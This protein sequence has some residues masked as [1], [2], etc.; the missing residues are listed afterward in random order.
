MG[1]TVKSMFLRILFFVPASWRCFSSSAEGGVCAFPKMLN[2]SVFTS[3]NST[4]LVKSSQ[5]LFCPA[6]RRVLAPSLTQLHV[7][8]THWVRP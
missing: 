1:V 4:S 7:R 2:S 5:Y 6:I 8:H 3:E